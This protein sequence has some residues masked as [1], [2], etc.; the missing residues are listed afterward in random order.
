MIL[1]CLNTITN[2]V[3]HSKYVNIIN[4]YVIKTIRSICCNV[5]IANAIIFKVY[6]YLNNFVATDSIRATGQTV[7]QT[8]LKTQLNQPTTVFKIDYQFDDNFS[9]KIFPP[10]QA[11]AGWPVPVSMPQTMYP[12]SQ[13]Y[14][15]S[16]VTQAM[17]QAP[18]PMTQ[19]LYPTS[20]GY[21]TSF[22]T[23]AMRQ[24][25]APMTQTVYPTS[26]GYQSNVTQ[27]MTPAPAPMP[28]TQ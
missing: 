6:F 3:N 23:Q 4:D 5:E 12:M 15:T 10:T 22:V 26:L 20:L 18:A 9:L 7:T 25:P 24:A 1:G 16:F 28:Q 13:G 19:T 14:P 21:P 17:R 8:L 11:P 2:H 27:A